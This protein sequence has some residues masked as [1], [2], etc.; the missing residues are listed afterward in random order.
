MGQEP[1]ILILTA[2]YG[3]GHHQVSKVLQQSLIRN[4]YCQVAVVD[5]FRE[6]YPVLNKIIRYLYRQS[7]YAASLGIPYY[8]WTYHLTNQL[9]MK[10]KIA[11]WMNSLGGDRLKKII[12]Q[13]QPEVIIYTF[14]FG[15][16]P[17]SVALSAIR[18]RT[19]V[20]ITDFDVH[21][22][23][24]FAK[25]DHYF[26]PASDVKEAMVRQGVPE[27]RITVTG[28]PVRESFHD[29]AMSGP[30]S[31]KEADE[32]VILL[33]ANVCGTLHSLSRLIGKLLLLSGVR[34]QVICGR[35]EGWRRKLAESWADD[36]RVDVFGFTDQLHVL[37][38]SACCVVTKA[39]GVTLSETIQAGVPIFILNPFL[40]QEKENALYLQ[41]K[42]AAVVAFTIHDLVLQIQAMI[43]SEQIKQSMMNGLLA[44]RQKAAADHIVRH[45]FPE[46]SP[47][48]RSGI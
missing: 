8:G 42:G 2:D 34:I 36:A 39:G 1:Q 9:P 17:S 41:R 27:S 18:P 4:G 14:P 7:L 47:L 3:E 37:M 5:L 10:G 21:R 23:W 12:L 26:V 13:Y 31:V 15:S 16:L 11:A 48:R 45:L 19:A 6:A 20:V 38:S 44:A 24:L 22:R 25:P 46:A 28:I 32:H 40:G 33:M 29:A 30:G 35:Q 43:S